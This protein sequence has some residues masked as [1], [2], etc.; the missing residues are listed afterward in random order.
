[1]LNVAKIFDFFSSKVAPCVN[2]ARVD[3]SWTVTCSDASAEQKVE[4][5]TSFQA[6]KDKATLG[7]DQGVLTA[8]VN[9]TFSSTASMNYDPSVQSSA[10]KLIKA[11]PSPLE[12]FIVGG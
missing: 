1:M 4:S 8:D 7:I 3:F 6:T 12:P 2:D 9:C 10:S 11:L 5:S